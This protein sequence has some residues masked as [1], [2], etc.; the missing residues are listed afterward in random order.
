METSKVATT[1]LYY[2]RFIQ[3]ERMPSFPQ[4]MWTQILHRINILM[5]IFQNRIGYRVGQSN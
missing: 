4:N 1:D 3:K 2:K 5:R